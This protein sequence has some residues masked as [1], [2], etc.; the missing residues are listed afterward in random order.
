[1]RQHTAARGSIL[2]VRGLTLEYE[3]ATHGDMWLRRSSLVTRSGVSEL[4]GS[5]GTEAVHAMQCT[6]LNFKQ[7]CRDE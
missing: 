4:Y 7:S 6:N 5:R 1:M 3:R 2:C